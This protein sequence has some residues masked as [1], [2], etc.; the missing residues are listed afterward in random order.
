MP[1]V[2]SDELESIHDASLRVLR[3]I[4]MDFLHPGA[5]R[6]WASAGASLDGNR[7]RFDPGL[8]LELV[9]QAPPRF[10]LHAPDPSKNLVFGGN[11]VAFG[12]VA[13]APNVSDRRSGRRTGNL[14]DFRHLV[15]LSDVLNAVH[16]H[17]GYPVEPVDVHPSIRHLVAL[18]DVLTL[19]GKC[20]MAYSLG[21]QRC[22]D[23]LEMVRLARGVSH[24]EFERQPSV[25]TVIN[26]NSPLK[27]DVPMLSGIME[28]SARNQPVIITPFTLAGAMAPVTV[29][30]AVV[31]Q[32][33]EAL[34]GIAF[35]QLV[36]PGAPVM[37]GSFT[38]NVDM[39]SG[40]P[41]FGTPEYM[42]ATLIGGQLARR[43]GV[44]YRS[45]NACA[46]NIV[47]AQAA[48]ESVFSLW[49]AVMG[50]AHFVMHGLGWMESG[51]CASYE[52]MV[53]DAD[54]VGTVAAF[55]DPVA[56]DE[57]SMGLDAIA[58]V[59]PGGHF[60]G[61]AHTRARYRHAFFQPMVSDWRNFETWRDGGS[62]SALDHAERLV[63]ELLEQHQPPALPDEANARLEDFVGYRIAEG[64]VPT[65]F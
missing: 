43:Y 40:S 52:K 42:Q 2:S 25:Q 22:R 6:R 57:A 21:R 58:E 38:S 19:S 46:A 3:D 45:S 49:G 28:F 61:A 32:N 10:T 47:D 34:A 17:G 26:T 27:L 63:G 20:P 29:A 41:A 50:G 60:F 37:Y 31:Q 30:G 62:P 54:L 14:E 36:R 51:L 59:G 64:G 9:A 24:E 56:V 48:W 5:R 11:H 12:A 1:A 18:R 23:A 15:K 33:A 8:V 7:V 65:D 53:T 44:P 16:L 13:S 35:A 4:G 55:L 39:R